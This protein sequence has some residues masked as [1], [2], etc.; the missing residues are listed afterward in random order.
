MK[1]REASLDHEMLVR[2]L[3]Y[4]PETGIFRWKISTSNRV[5]IGSVAGYEEPRGYIIIS[6]GGVRYSGHRL[7]LFY[8]NG[9][10][11]PEDVDHV[12]LIKSDNRFAN[13]REATRAEN[14]WNVGVMRTNTSGYKG[15]RV[16]C[17]KA[18]AQICIHGKQHYLGTFDSP[19]KAHQAYVEAS[20]RW[21]G[22][23]GRRS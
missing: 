4:E 20:R 12:N 17:G 18:E 14:K 15:V 6:V 19:E 9:T 21:H 23:Y 1:P 7:A 13:L 3:D 2:L 16:R 8:V 22:E 10:W 5:S 11:P